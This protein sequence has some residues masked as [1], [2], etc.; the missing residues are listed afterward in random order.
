MV[1]ELFRGAN[2]TYDVQCWK[3]HDSNSV[4]CAD[5]GLSN[6]TNLK[7]LEMLVDFVQ[8]DNKCVH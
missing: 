8:P 4:D 1:E 2:M 3:E 7:H 6:Y 5:I